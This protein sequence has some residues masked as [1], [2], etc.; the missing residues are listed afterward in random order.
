MKLSS[1]L[2]VASLVASAAVQA[3]GAQQPSPE[4]QAMRKACSAD[5][6]KLCS[7]K[8]GHEAMECLRENS[9]KVSQDCKDA[10]AK[11][12]PAAPH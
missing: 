1:F 7:G 11:M 8:H 5:A 12:K 2:A 4:M 3:Q 6:Q 9:D 10:M